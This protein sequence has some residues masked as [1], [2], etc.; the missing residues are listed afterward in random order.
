MAPVRVDRN[1]NRK[2]GYRQG[3]QQP[4]RHP[5]LFL[6]DRTPD[7]DEVVFTTG[8]TSVKARPLD[9]DPRFAMVVDDQEPPYSYALLEGERTC[10][11]T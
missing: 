2:A 9:R 5:D 8:D 11:A 10:R 7:G 6:I 1:S 3:E 4:A